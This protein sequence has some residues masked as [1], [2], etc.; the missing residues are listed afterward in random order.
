MPI[1]E[2]AIIV[3]VAL[4]LYILPQQATQTERGRIVNSCRTLGSFE[5][6]GVVFKCRTYQPRLPKNSHE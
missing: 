4:A 6:D 2:V 3:C 5:V 1:R